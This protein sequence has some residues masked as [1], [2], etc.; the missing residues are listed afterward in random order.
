MF[1]SYVFASASRATHTR[2]FKIQILNCFKAL[3]SFACMSLFVILHTCFQPIWQSSD[4]LKLFG[5]ITALLFTVVTFSLTL[6]FNLKFWNII[7]LFFFAQLVLVT[8][9]C[10]V[11]C[12]FPFVMSCVDVKFWILKL[13]NVSSTEDRCECMRKEDTVQQDAAIHHQCIC[14]N[15]LYN[16]WY[17]LA[18]RNRFFFSSTAHC[19]CAAAFY[20]RTGYYC[21]TAQCT[22]PSAL[23]SNTGN[24]LRK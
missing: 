18:L 7:S 10:V 14:F 2:S 15:S 21:S 13:F 20:P 19:T 9:I 24:V 11:M 1:L 3:N 17:Q 6:R 8:Y 5:E 23:C 22:Y 16:C 4:V 12:V